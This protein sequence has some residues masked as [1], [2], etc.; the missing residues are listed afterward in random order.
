MAFIRMN[1]ILSGGSKHVLKGVV[2]IT[3]TVLRFLHCLASQLY[4]IIFY[5]GFLKYAF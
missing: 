4:L 1:L 3:G 5:N 2:R